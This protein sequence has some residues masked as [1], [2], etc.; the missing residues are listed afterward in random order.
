MFCHSKLH[1]ISLARYEKLYLRFVEQF[2]F[3]FICTT[4]N[5]SIQMR[6]KT[7]NKPCKTLCCL[8]W[9]PWLRNGGQLCISLRGSLLGKV[10]FRTYAE[11]G[12]GSQMIL[13]NIVVIIIIINSNL[14]DGFPELFFLGLILTEPFENNLA[15]VRK[16][17]EALSDDNDGHD[18]WRWWRCWWWGL[19][20][21]WW[22]VSP[23][24]LIGDIDRLLF[25]WVQAQHAHCLIFRCLK[26]FW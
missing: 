7:F 4:Y 19:E 2:H 1:C 11:I 9:K 12:E 10:R 23:C 26:Y 25:S 20:W 24:H 17:D 16:V 15:E 18:S 8:F 21:W 22:W 13:L 14:K 5:T 3:R 6:D